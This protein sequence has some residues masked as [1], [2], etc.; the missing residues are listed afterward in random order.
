MSKPLVSVI[1][2]TF[3]HANV[4]TACIESVLN[5]TYKNLEIIVVD[6]GST[7]NTREVLQKF[8]NK[9]QILTQENQGSNPARNRGWKQA[10]GE[11]LIFCDADVVMKL[12]MI[13]KMY[14]ALEN[15]PQASFTY[16]AFKFGWKIFHGINFDAKKLREHNYIHTT[17]LVRA[18]DFPGFDP[19]IRRLQDWDVWLTMLEQ[20]KAGVLVDQVLYSVD[21]SGASRIG[22][23][24]LPSIFYKLPWKKFG[25]TPTRVEKYELAH[26]IICDKHKL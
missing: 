2:P 21:I 24:W 11:Y 18:K 26:R 19:Q 5:Q 8:A 23:S 14:Q 20:G 3:E 7:D 15:N 17:S 4:L 6:D 12:N 25:W 13:E 1:I 9:I 16:S 22:S 10:S